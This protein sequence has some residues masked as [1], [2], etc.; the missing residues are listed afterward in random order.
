[1]VSI[2]GWRYRDI[3]IKQPLRLPAKVNIIIRFL[4]TSFSSFFVFT[5]VFGRF[6]LIKMPARREWDVKT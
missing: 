5:I 3:A 1:M 6:Q 2:P 4:S